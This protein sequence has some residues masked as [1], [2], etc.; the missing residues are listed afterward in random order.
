[1]ALVL[2]KIQAQEMRKIQN[3]TLT[4][5]ATGTKKINGYTRLRQT[6]SEGEGES[7]YGSNIL[8]GC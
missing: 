5:T 1:M 2:Q 6:L 4:K 3:L 8:I 7:A